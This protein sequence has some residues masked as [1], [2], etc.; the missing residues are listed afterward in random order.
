MLLLTAA[1]TAVALQGT[2]DNDFRW[3]GTL[4]AGKTIEIRGINGAIT[5]S[6]AS[7]REVRVAAVK[8]AR[9]SDVASVEIRVEENSDG[10]TICAVYPNQRDSE[11]C[12]LESR[13]NRNSEENDVQVDFTVEVPANVK[14]AGRTVNGDVEAAGLTGDAEITTVN[15]NA[16]VSTRGMAEATTVNGNVRASV[17]RADW[18]GP[19]EFTTVNGSVT[20]TLP[21][22][23]DAD[24]TASTVN[25]DISTDFPLTVRGRFGPRRLSGTIGD[26]GRALSLKTVNGSISIEREG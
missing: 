22:S 13:N 24:V 3:S 14:F 12:R 23:V 4:A 10:V 8:R 11:G 21:A 19:A 20:V 5:A 17:G 6:A 7:G 2:Q 15:G 1:L 26:G 9:R 16:E 25:G 18:S